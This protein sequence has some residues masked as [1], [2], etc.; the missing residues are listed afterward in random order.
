MSLREIVPGDSQGLYQMALVAP[1]AVTSSSGAQIR[2]SFRASGAG[3]ADAERD[4]FVGFGP[5]GVPHALQF[6][7]LRQPA[8]P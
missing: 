6:I 8:S 2:C 4:T 7:D 5:P 1:P 3:Q